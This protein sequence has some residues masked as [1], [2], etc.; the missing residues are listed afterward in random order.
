MTDFETNLFTL[1]VE[2][3]WSYGARLAGVEDPNDIVLGLHGN[4]MELR[5]AADQWRACAGAVRSVGDRLAIARNEVSDHWRGPAFEAFD[6]YLTVYR[7]KLLGPG[8]HGAGLSGVMDE[9]ADVLEQTADAVV[10]A[11]EAATFLA[12][13][14]YGAG[15]AVLGGEF[16]APVLAAGIGGAAVGFGK[17]LFE[18]MN[19]FA[20]VL[21][22]LDAAAS[23]I[24]WKEL[25]QP[26]AAF[27]RTNSLRLPRPEPE[28]NEWDRWLPISVA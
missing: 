13:A 21:E 6:R 18:L 20:Q 10:H 23:R 8:D 28:V 27:N 3:F 12:L 24:G 22:D 4:P 17:D 15:A 2:A 7:E 25:S 14:W 1:P 5:L 26:L 16:V 11:R 9:L 19:E